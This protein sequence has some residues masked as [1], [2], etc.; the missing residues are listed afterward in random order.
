MK[1]SFINIALILIFLALVGLI[2]IL[3]FFYYHFITFAD[4]IEDGTSEIEKLNDILEKLT[5]SFSQLESKAKILF[6]EK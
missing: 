2:T 4:Y 1:I 5:E 3:V 6:E